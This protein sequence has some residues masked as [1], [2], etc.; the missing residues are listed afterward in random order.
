MTQNI[1]S[2]WEN[3]GK[4]HAILMKSA[5]DLDEIARIRK[6]NGLELDETTTHLLHQ[7][8]LNSINAHRIKGSYEAKMSSVCRTTQ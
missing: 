1:D 5:L 6:N 7:S 3:L 2:D 4:H 8:Y